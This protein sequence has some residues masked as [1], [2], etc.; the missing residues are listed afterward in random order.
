MVSD[1]RTDTGRAG[2]G[3]AGAAGSVTRGKYTLKVVPWPGSLYTQ[4]HPPL[5]L[6]IPYT[7]ASPRPVPLPAG[8]VVK[9]GSKI[10]RRV[11]SSIPCPVSDTSR[12]TQFPERAEPP[13][14][15]AG[16]LDVRSQQPGQHELGLSQRFVQI[17]GAE[18]KHLLAAEGEEL[19]GNGRGL[20]SSALDL[21][22]IG[23]RGGFFR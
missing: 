14:T 19:F 2:L 7:V 15:S 6:T 8:L 9:K 18:F 23:A 21:V 5:C 10:W 16:E 17:Q 1:P 13:G 11:F 12:T 3:A 4:I 22:Q 20:F